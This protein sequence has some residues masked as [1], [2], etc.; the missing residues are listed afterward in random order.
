MIDP[1]LIPLVASRFKMLGEPGRLAI[2]AALHERERSVGELA[3]L[4]GRGQPNVSQQ[5]AGLSRAGLVASRRE[6]KHVI[7]CVADP[8][9]A[10]ICDAVCA[11][12]AARARREEPLRKALGRARAVAR[13]RA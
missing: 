3:D 1:G 2:L 5:L 8:Y 6:G 12:L 7:Y 10:R 11:S 13:T 4:T 9:V